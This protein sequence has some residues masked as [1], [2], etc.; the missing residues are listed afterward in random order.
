[1]AS[2]LSTPWQTG[3]MPISGCMNI[4]SVSL[5]VPSA[6]VVLVIST[7]HLWIDHTSGTPDTWDFLNANSATDCS[8]GDP[9][10]LQYIGNMPSDDATGLYDMSGTVVS[11]FVVGGAG[12]VTFY[13]NVMMLAG[14]S[15]N[16]IVSEASTVAVFYPS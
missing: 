3:G 8:L 1:M 12:T 14:A 7:A 6:G 9:S 11:T 15:G 16:D 10:R 4:H 2:V 13:L 5:T